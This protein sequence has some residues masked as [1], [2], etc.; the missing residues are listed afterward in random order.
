MPYRKKKRSR[1]HR[2][3]RTHGWGFGKR[4]R[5]KGNKPY[6]AGGVGK[7]GA[8]RETFFSA[9]GGEPAIGKHGIQVKP[10]TTVVK[11]K[12]ISLREMEEFMPKWLVEKKA[13]KSS[14]GTIVLDL[15]KLGYTKLL[16]EGTVTRKMQITCASCSAKV[17]GKVEGAGGSITLK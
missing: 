16:S 1:K 4:H 14:D 15:K 7:R 5:G 3:G 11:G 17:K 10:R 12:V 8:H 9:H 2:G 13:E 6:R